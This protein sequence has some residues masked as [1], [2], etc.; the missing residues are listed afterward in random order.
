MSSQILAEGSPI[1]AGS[2]IAS[3]RQAQRD[4]P[5]SV[6]VCYEFRTSTGNSHCSND[7]EF[8]LSRPANPRICAPNKAARVF[9]FR[10][11]VAMSNFL[12]KSA[13]TI[14]FVFDMIPPLCLGGA[15]PML[16]VGKS[17]RTLREKLG[18]TMRDVE[19]SS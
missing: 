17:L 14:A 13:T 16:R 1:A 8:G 7:A 18:L 9:G 15:L 5:V 10:N 6:G 19:N 3:P 2:A 4:F 12:H 11:R